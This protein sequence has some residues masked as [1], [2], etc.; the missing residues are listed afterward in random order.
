M[1]T[2]ASH[3]IY[4]YYNQVLVHLLINYNIIKMIMYFLSKLYFKKSS[5]IIL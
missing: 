1:T 4:N 2:K 5:L 3:I